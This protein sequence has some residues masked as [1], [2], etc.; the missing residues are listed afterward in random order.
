[1]IGTVLLYDEWLNARPWD[2]LLALG[3]LMTVAVIPVVVKFGSRMQERR[4]TR[5]KEEFG[6]EYDEA[7]AEHGHWLRA[8]SALMARRRSRRRN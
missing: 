7:I 3:V 6:T 2:T 1:M 4:T 5:L 8:E